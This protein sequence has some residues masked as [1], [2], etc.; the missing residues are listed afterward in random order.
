MLKCKG[1]DLTLEGART[2]LLAGDLDH[3]QAGAEALM[4]FA[5]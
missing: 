4:R 5:Q 3:A 2:H 1:V